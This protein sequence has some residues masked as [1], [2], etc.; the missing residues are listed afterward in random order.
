MGKHVNI[1]GNCV[2]VAGVTRA[3]YWGQAKHFDMKGT[4]AS[5]EESH[6]GRVKLKSGEEIGN[7]GFGAL[8]RVCNNCVRRQ[9]IASLPDVSQS[10]DVETPPSLPPQPL[11]QDPVAGEQRTVEVQLGPSA[12]GTIRR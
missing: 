5:V 11:L 4:I 7:G 3:V 8:V 2:L 6:S 10:P 1:T 12:D 9:V